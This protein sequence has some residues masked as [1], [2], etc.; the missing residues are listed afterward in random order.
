MSFGKPFLRVLIPTLLFLAGPAALADYHLWTISEVFSNADGRVQFVELSTQ[1]TGQGQLSGHTL[2]VTDG[3]QGSRSFQFASNLSGETAG[4]T[5]LIA[6]ARFTGLTGLQADYTIPEGF[7]F[8]NGGTINFGEG[9]SSLSYSGAQLPKN[10]TQSMTGGGQP[11]T[12]SPRNFAGLTAT[13]SAPTYASFDSTT[14]IMTVPVLNAPGIGVANVRFS[15]NL[16]TLQFTLLDGFYLYGSGIT[17]GN[18]PA[19]FVNNSVLQLPALVVGSDLYNANLAIVGE[20]PIRF[21]NPQVVSV[22]AVPVIPLPQTPTPTPTPTPTDQQS[23]TR[24]RSSYGALCVS[25]HGSSGEGG[26]GPAL[27]SSGFNTFASLRTKIDTT[28]PQGAPAQCRD[29]G[30]STCATDIANYIINTFQNGGGVVEP[31]ITY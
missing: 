5:L 26:I 27:T 12:A 25:C 11:Q 20:N 30:G 23:I 2:V 9:A 13:V 19:Q 16:G 6:T 14:S 29:G 24:G 3:G 18:N 21:G 10:G 17:T 31:T 22:T 4:R 7:L 8:L 15:V 1:S 28:M